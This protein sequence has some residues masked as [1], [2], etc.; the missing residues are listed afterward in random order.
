MWLQRR[1]TVSLA[2]A[3]E[4]KRRHVL[5]D[6]KVS[7]D[8]TNALF[9]AFR[10]VTIYRHGRFPLGNR[11]FVALFADASP[12]KDVSRLLRS[13]AERSTRRVRMAAVACP[14]APIR[15]CLSK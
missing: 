14:A 9:E 5:S 2:E 11:L 4:T 1:E 8:A 10:W 13:F 12:Q 7:T 15:T 3:R 6:A